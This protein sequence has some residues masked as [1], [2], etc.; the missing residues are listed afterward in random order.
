MAFE[1]PSSGASSFLGQTNIVAP[2][3][4]IARALFLREDD[5]SWLS[6][7]SHD[8]EAVRV[9]VME[10]TDAVV[11]AVG[12]EAQGCASQEEDLEW[13]RKRLHEV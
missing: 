6:A 5:A 7:L 13:T 8:I 4:E 11:A 10:S 3:T 9:A 1:G 2:E 12:N